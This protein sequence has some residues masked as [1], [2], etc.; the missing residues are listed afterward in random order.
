[1]ARVNAR[2]SQIPRSFSVLFVKR[3]YLPAF[4]PPSGPS[5]Q[6][7]PLFS[8]IFSLFTHFPLAKRGN[9]QYNIGLCKKLN[10]MPV[11]SPRRR[12]RVLPGTGNT[13]GEGHYAE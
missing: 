5:A 6:K 8:K 2:K 4:S 1:M 12:A 7:S 10:K 3:Y 9:L 11:T 13:G